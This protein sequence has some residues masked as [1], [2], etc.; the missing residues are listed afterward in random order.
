MHKKSSTGQGRSE[1]GAVVKP[2]G[3]RTTVGLVFPGTYYVGMSSLGYQTIYRII[4]ARRN[5]L[6]ERLFLPDAKSPSS[7]SPLS[8][9]ITSV[10]SK[11]RARDFEILGFSVAFEH[12]YAGV[13]D[14]LRLSGIPPFSRDRDES[15]PLLILG[16]VCTFFNPEPIA[17]FFDA[18]IVGEAEESI[19][20]F[21]DEYV[22]AKSSSRQELLVNLS[23]I[24]GVYIPSL[25]TPS[26]NTDGT[27]R[28]LTAA[29]GAPE[30]V[31]RRY[32][33]DL[34]KF[35]AKSAIITPDTEFSDMFMIELSRGCGRH[36]RFCMAGYV[37]R[38]PRNRSFESVKKDIEEGRKLAGK[39]GL[40]GSAVSD[41][42]E[43]AALAS[44]FKD[45]EINFSASSLR[46]DSLTPELARLVSK[47]NR[48]VAIAPEAG[49]ERLRAVINKN[50][51]QEQVLSAVRT[52]I[53]A[54]VLNV[55]LYFMVGLPTERDEDIEEIIA[56]ASRTREEMLSAARGKGRMGTLSLSVN[57]FVPK[58]WTPFQWEPMQTADKLK[59]KIQHIAKALKGPNMAVTHDVPKYAVLQAALARGDR[60]LAKVI[61]NASENGGDWKAAFADEGLDMEV[62]ASRERGVQE[63]FAWDFLDTGIKKDFLLKERE[64][65]RKARHTPRCAP[66][67][68]RTCGVCVGP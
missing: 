19:N 31:V 45:Q 18:V 61:L 43:I 2:R 60:R 64:R 26:Y 59:S 29:P 51:S 39:I 25:Y 23:K 48:T 37:Y 36:C 58:P 27:L 5:A 16:G 10:E 9:P 20:E 35:P 49:S 34:D 68:C 12:D 21:L 30:K 8:S 7:L 17:D 53:E 55:K 4:N 63:K 24:P 42:P 13:A 3:G 67:K 33:K 38:P 22:N 46:A 65:A 1:K 62:Y 50:I 66:G 14:F 28:S 56:L 52:L 11:T 15:H 54:G 6:A 44:E 32:V 57:C 40:V 47:G 41:Y